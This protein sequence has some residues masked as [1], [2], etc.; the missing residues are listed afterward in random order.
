MPHVFF[1]SYAQANIDKELE[2]FFEDLCD[3]V[4]V[5]TP[6]YTAK[7]SRLHFRDKTG[8]PLM[9]E[10][11]PHIMNALQTSSVLVCVTSPA[12]F[13]SRF[14]G[15]EF[16]VFDQRRRAFDVSAPPPV[17][18]PIVWARTRGAPPGIMNLVQWQQGGMDPDYEAKGLRNL[19]KVNPPSMLAA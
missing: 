17:I 7:D 8:I 12:Y 11:Q 6:G 19:K 14:C 5:Y 16:Y 4:K 18:L 13:A 3:E 2:S 9:E 1:F 15:Q 10:W